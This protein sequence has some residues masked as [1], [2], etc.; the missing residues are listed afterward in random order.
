[1]E[2]D[3]LIEDWVLSILFRK[4]FHQNMWDY[5]LSFFW[6]LIQVLS[7]L[8]PFERGIYE[9]YVANFW[10]TT[11]VIVKWKRLFSTQ[12]LR[13]LSL[14]STVSTCLPSMLLLIL[15]PSRRNF[16][17]G[18]LSSSLSF[19]FFSF[20]GTKCLFDSLILPCTSTYVILLLSSQYNSNWYFC[21]ELQ[22]MRNLFCC[23]FFQ[24]AS[25]RL[26]N[27]LYFAG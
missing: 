18:L 12:A 2:I 13:I 15:A 6:C 5:W 17:F 27:L 23:L 26:M 9:D 1:M 8:A 21:A 22:F 7:R 4:Y 20:Q 24:Q 3:D 19:Y 16:L 25:W 10:C 11:S 14:V